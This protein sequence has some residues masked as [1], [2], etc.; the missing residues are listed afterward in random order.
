MKGNFTELLNTETP[1]LVDFSAEWCVPCKA[2]SPILQDLAARI[3]DKAKIIKIDVDKNPELASHFKITG[4]PTL[5]LFKK[6]VTKWRQSG[7]LSAQALEEII[8]THTN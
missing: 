8:N 4:V 7:V 2:M 1:V 6:G 5:M 3:G